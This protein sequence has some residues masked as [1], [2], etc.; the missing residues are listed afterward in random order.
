MAAKLSRHSP[1]FEEENLKQVNTKYS[2]GVSPAPQEQQCQ[3]TGRALLLSPGCKQR[4]TRWLPLSS[5]SA[6]AR[7]GPAAACLTSPAS[8]LNS[9]CVLPRPAPPG[10]ALRASCKAAFFWLSGV[11]PL[12]EGV[13]GQGLGPGVCSAA[14]PSCT[15]LIAAPVVRPPGAP[16]RPSFA[17]G[18]P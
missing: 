15:L 7:W 1:C 3:L 11:S 6:G 13:A 2:T 9:P 17:P 12:T 10:V 8:V 4:A 18:V 14:L 16:N 5:P